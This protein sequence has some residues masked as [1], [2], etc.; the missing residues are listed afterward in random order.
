[1]FDSN[2]MA[3]RAAIKR[4]QG[5]G[6]RKDGCNKP[7]SSKAYDERMGLK[8]MSTWRR[9]VYEATLLWRS[10][11]SS[12]CSGFRW[13]CHWYTLDKDEAGYVPF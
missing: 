5:G 13:D 7:V 6:R 2:A 11:S 4:A 3:E 10:D 1:M 9:A 8:E 12:A